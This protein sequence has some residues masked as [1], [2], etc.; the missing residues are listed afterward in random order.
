MSR[1]IRGDI[2]GWEVVSRS[3]VHAVFKPRLETSLRMLWTG[4]LCLA[5]SCGLYLLGIRGAW[6]NWIVHGMLLVFALLM[7]I[8][9]FTVRLA[10]FRDDAAGIARIWARSQFGRARRTVPLGAS[11]FRVGVAPFRSGQ[12]LEGFVWRLHVDGPEPMVFSLTEPVP[13]DRQMPGDAED[14][15]KHIMKLLSPA[16]PRKRSAKEDEAVSI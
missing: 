16:P 13:E 5:M 6:Y 15:A 14:L 3:D 9:P 1:P 4:V 11:A 7:F 12:R 10:I 2:G 8:T